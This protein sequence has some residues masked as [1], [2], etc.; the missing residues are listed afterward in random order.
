M[1]GIDWKCGVCGTSNKIGCDC[2]VKLRCPHCRRE[3][4][5][6]REDHD[7]P[8]TARIET[9]C[10]KCGNGGDRPEVLYFDAAGKQLSG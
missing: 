6:R 1:D 3:K 5:V 10:D 7:L 9:Q 8:G 2:F 4:M